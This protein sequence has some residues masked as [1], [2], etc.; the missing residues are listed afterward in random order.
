MFREELLV[1]S[2]LLG[3]HLLSVKLEVVEVICDLQFLL[4]LSLPID[5]WV[6]LRL[7]LR[8]LQDLEVCQR[9]LH[10]EV[11]CLVIHELKVRLLLCLRQVEFPLAFAD[12]FEF[13][14][15][16]L[17]LREESDAALLA[18]F[19]G[20]ELLEVVEEAVMVRD[21]GLWLVLRLLLGG[22][23]AVSLLK[24]LMLGIESRQQGQHPLFVGCV[25]AH[26]FGQS[27]VLSGLVLTGVLAILLDHCGD[28]VYEL[29]V[30]WRVQ[31]HQRFDVDLLR[32]ETLTFVDL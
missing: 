21:H 25:A 2:L 10:S 16:L 30:G 31:T 8:L 3:H 19:F 1:F 15:Q 29:K 24:D 6:G 32:T 22:W 26:V 9:Y 14:L 5:H 27:M 13:E 17:T 7:Q 20:G 11:V 12:A 23:W 28:D 18:K 4:Y